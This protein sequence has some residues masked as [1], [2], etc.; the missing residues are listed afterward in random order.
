MATNRETLIKHYYSIIKFMD[1]QSE[2]NF[3]FSTKEILI[4]FKTTPTL[5]TKNRTFKTSL[6]SE[7]EVIKR[8][9]SNTSLTRIS[10]QF[11][12]VEDNHL[13]PILSL[14]KLKEL[15]INGC[16]S[17]SDD[18]INSIEN[19]EE[20]TYVELYWMPQLKN[21][22]KILMNIS[23]ST[24]NFSYLNLSGCKNINSNCFDLIAPLSKLTFLDLTRCS[25][26]DKQ[27]TEISI[28]LRLLKHLN[29]YAIPYLKCEFLEYL[30]D[31]IEFLD[32]CGNQVVEDKDVLKMKTGKLKYL[33]LVCYIS[34]F[35][36]FICIRL[37]VIDLLMCLLSLFL[38]ILTV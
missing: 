7:E 17:V 22:S 33:N 15:T 12:S 37:G 27:I 13:N 36:L 23:K 19:V 24:T 38:I 14:K 4:K 28:R 18:L 5:T 1:F 29:L 32:L 30:S 8:L 20:L 3:S 11:K 26:N 25:I 6:L 34:I 10:L 9:L 2:V 16:H 35:I 21:I 31:N